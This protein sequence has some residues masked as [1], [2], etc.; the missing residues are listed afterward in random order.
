MVSADTG[1]TS[2]NF[3]F[4]GTHPDTD[5]YYVHYHFDGV[6][7][8]GRAHADGNSN[9]V[10][11]N[12]NCPRRR[13]RFSRR[14]IRFSNAPIAC[15]GTPAARGRNGVGS[16]RNESWKCGRPR[17]PCRRSLTA[18]CRAPGACSVG[19]TASDRR[20]SSSAPATTHSRPSARRTPRPATHAWRDIVLREGRSGYARESRRRGIW[21]SDGARHGSRAPRC[22]GGLRVGDCRARDLRRGAAAPQRNVDHRR[23]R[24]GAAPRRRAAFRAP[25]ITDES[26]EPVAAV[27]RSETGGHWEQ[28]KGDWWQTSVTN[29]Q[30][31]GQVVPRMSG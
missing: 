28:L 11:P 21:R 29:C 10:I 1:G 7:W 6:G 12:G 16:D 22:L 24:D 20:C 19:R 15:G 5:R 17:S 13:S 14:A 18:W 25:T 26:R 2:C 23:R 27:P 9:Q 4:G 8:G 31:C 30:L 3:L